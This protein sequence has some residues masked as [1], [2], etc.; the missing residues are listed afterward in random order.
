MPTTELTT[1]ELASLFHTD[2]ATI[3][4]AL[5]RLVPGH[6]RGA[7]WVVRIETKSVN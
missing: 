1:R 4:K 3:R 5:R 7:K 6:K 2:V